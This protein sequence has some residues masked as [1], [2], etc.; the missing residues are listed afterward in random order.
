MTEEV[1]IRDAQLSE[2]SEQIKG[3]LDG[4]EKSKRYEIDIDHCQDLIEQFKNAYLA[5]QMDVQA[6]DQSN[7]RARRVYKPKLRDYRQMQK[8]FEEDLK[9]KKAANVRNDL[10]AD[11]IAVDVVDYDTSEGLQKHGRNLL[12]Q[13]SDMLK[14]ARSVVHQTIEIGGSTAAKLDKQTAQIADIHDNLESMGNTIQRST[15]IIRRMARKVAT[16]KYIWAITG[17]VFIG[18]FAIIIYESTSGNDGDVN[19]PSNGPLP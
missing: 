18:I 12:Q 19:T 7:A 1:R 14:G 3:V 17:L 8:Q 5:M 2:L 10:V 16:D 6:L 15:R 11:A 13:D 9:W 4:L